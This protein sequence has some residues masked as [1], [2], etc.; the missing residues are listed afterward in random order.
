MGSVCHLLKASS[1]GYF[2]V[3]GYTEEGRDV[4][5]ND[6]RLICLVET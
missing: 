1:A 3:R 5:D 4:C 6:Y 2:L